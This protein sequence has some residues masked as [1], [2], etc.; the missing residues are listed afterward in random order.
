[1]HMS[2][3]VSKQML[4]KSECKLRACVFREWRLSAW[5]VD[6]HVMPA[7]SHH[8]GVTY[9]G[10]DPHHIA[11]FTTAVCRS[12]RQQPPLILEHA[13]RGHPTPTMTVVNQRR[14]TGGEIVACVLF[15]AFY[16]CVK[17]QG[18]EIRRREMR[19]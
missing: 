9:Q 17:T 5:H 2:E 7:G 11:N 16:E 18:G 3:R 4:S 6:S 1:M 14:Q 10:A 8:V 15:F 13:G 19:I 12:T